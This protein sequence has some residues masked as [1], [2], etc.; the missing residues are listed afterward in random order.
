MT[1]RHVGRLAPHTQAV[2]ATTSGSSFDTPVPFVTALA[3][4]ASVVAMLV[5]ERALTA[6]WAAANHGAT[7]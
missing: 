6:R 1:A 3:T 4:L 5:R 2:I 7:G